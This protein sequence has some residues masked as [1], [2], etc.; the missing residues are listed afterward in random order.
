MNKDLRDNRKVENEIDLIELF[1]YL[2]KKWLVIFLCTIVGIV[3]S[4]LYTRY[5]VTPM[6]S[7]SSLVYI[8]GASSTISTLTDIQIGFYLADD[9]EVIFKSRTVMEKVVNKLNLKTSASA[10]GARVTV[11]NESGRNTLKISATAD[12]PNDARDIVNAV[13]EYGVDMVKEINTKEPY[14]IEKAIA[15]PSKVSPSMTKNVFVGAIGGLAFSIALYVV[16][17]LVNDYVTDVETIE[18]KLGIPVIGSIPESEALIYKK[19]H[20]KKRHR[21]HSKKKDSKENK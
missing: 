2:T 8:R 12:N 16:I 15:N 17:Y 3:A 4:G 20:K 13:V 10:L 6:Y 11:S 18:F 21:H 9:Y 19:G 1:K 5:L 7:S 14:I